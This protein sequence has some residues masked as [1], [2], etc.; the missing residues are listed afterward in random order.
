M[1]GEVGV[2][3]RRLRPQSLWE[4]QYGRTQLGRKVESLWEQFQRA[5]RS[6]AEGTEHQKI[7][8][9][10]LKQKDRKNSRMIK[11]QAK[12]LQKLQ[13]AAGHGV[14]LR[15]PPSLRSSFA[16]PQELVAA[17]R[18]Q[19]VAQRREGEEQNRWVRA[20]KDEVRRELQE[21]G[22]AMS[23]A[24]SDA[25]GELARLSAQSSAA[26][27]MLTRVVRKVR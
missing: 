2:T 12:K 13:V 22:R 8:F 5:L 16:G 20:E 6:Y 1:R 19:I 10:A 18:G 26:L 21:L 25:R 3:R 23:Q 15:W 11:S 4:T 24:R 14:Q 17:S 9:E 7:A 27:K